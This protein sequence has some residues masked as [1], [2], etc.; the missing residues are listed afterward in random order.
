MA[1]PNALQKV[2]DHLKAFVWAGRPVAIRYLERNNY[3]R[4]PAKF[5][6]SEE[7]IC[8]GNCTVRRGVSTVRIFLPVLPEADRL[9]TLRHECGHIRYHFVERLGDEAGVEA[10]GLFRQIEP[11]D[12]ALY[13][14]RPDGKDVTGE[15]VVRL[16]DRLRAGLPVP[17]MSPA[18]ALVVRRVMSPAPASALGFVI[19]AA[20]LLLAGVSAAS[21]SDLIAREQMVSAGGVIWAEGTC[22]REQGHPL[23]GT[24]TWPGADDLTARLDAVSIG[25]IEGTANCIDIAAICADRPAGHVITRNIPQPPPG[26]TFPSSLAGVQRIECAG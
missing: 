12:A 2:M 24:W 21:A 6:G 7:M 14:A 10:R 4:D 13:D 26:Y 23:V 15:A 18:L 11:A 25:H 19:L 17:D 20:G 16:A 9:D 22:V 8:D 1:N 5:G 3:F